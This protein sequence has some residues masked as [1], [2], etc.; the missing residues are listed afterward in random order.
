MKIFGKMVLLA[1]VAVM[2]LTVN[3]SPGPDYA[4]TKKFGKKDVIKVNTISGDCIVRKA[5]DD[6]IEVM[7]LNNHS[8]RDAFEPKFRVSGNT[9][10]LDERTNGSTNGN[11]MWA[12]SVPEGTRVEFE[13][14][15]GGLSIYGLEGVFVAKT[16]SGNIRIEDCRGRFHMSTASGDVNASGVVIEGNSTFGSASG[17][18]N[19]KLAQSAEHDLHLGTASGK[20]ILDYCG[21][22]IKG[23]FEFTAK[24]RQ[25][26]IV[27]PFDF[28][29]EEEFDNHHDLY[30]R[31]TAIKEIEDPH[32]TI[33]TASG[34]AILRQ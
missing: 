27:S 13:S 16:T 29:A 6:G 21:N 14:A 4:I 34:R 30:V 10:K 7:V 1:I 8:P 12:L 23:H 22:P 11:S 20:A 25:G 31:K 17:V 26:R 24:A 15:S 32:V 2:V 9:L 28:D 19:V 3:A 33:G 5:V 18:V